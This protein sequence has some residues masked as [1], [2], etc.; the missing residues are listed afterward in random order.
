MLNRIPNFTYNSPKA[1]DSYS[2]SIEM[3]GQPIHKIKN[4]E[5]FYQCLGYTADAR[6]SGLLPDEFIWEK[7]IKGDP[8]NFADCL[9]MHIVEYLAKNSITFIN[10]YGNQY[11]NWLEQH[12]EAV[13][14]KNLL[15]V[16]CR[17]KS[18]CHIGMSNFQIPAS[19]STWLGGIDNEE[20]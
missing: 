2:A 19:L 12:V 5:A 8:F 17:S 4:L 10:E 7:Y 1:S 6:K 15:C 20:T 13:T 3:D 9:Q 14:E 16:T 11:L 18:F